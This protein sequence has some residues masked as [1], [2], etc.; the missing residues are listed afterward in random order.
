[1]HLLT[2]VPQYEQSRVQLCPS[3]H[4]DWLVLE[5]ILPAQGGISRLYTP[6]DLLSELPTASARRAS[7]SSSFVLELAANASRAAP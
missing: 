1:M 2:Y 3:T 4:V 6:C 5:V 7:F